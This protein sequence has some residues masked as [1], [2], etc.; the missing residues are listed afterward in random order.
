MSRFTASNRSAEETARRGHP[1]PTPHLPIDNLTF[2]P[3]SG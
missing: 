3:T 1:A 2:S